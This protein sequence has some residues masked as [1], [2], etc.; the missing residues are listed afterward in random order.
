VRLEGLEFLNEEVLKL[1]LNLPEDLN[2]LLAD[3]GEL[4]LHNL[5]ELLVHRLERHSTDGVATLGDNLGVVC[6]STTVPCQNVGGVTGDIG[7]RVLGGD[8]E[9]ASLQLSRGDC[10]DSVR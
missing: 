3:L 10:L 6:T 9:K 1:A 5:G 7:Q 2:S 8:G 4:L